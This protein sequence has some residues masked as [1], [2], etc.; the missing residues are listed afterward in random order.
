MNARSPRK[1]RGQSE[2][3]VFF[4]VRDEDL[5][6]ISTLEFGSPAFLY[7]S[8]PDAPEFQLGVETGCPELASYLLQPNQWVPGTVRNRFKNK[9]ENN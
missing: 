8:C 6:G 4:G 7:K 1:Q 9:M 2:F 5:V 3:K